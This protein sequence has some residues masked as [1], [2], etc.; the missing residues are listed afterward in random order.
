MLKIPSKIHQKEENYHKQERELSL[1]FLTVMEIS[2][3]N[4]V[5]P[6]PNDKI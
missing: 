2:L 1:C 4:C 5:N 6:F 3:R